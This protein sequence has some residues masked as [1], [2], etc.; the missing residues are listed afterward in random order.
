MG[1]GLELIFGDHHKY[2]RN[3]KIRPSPY[4]NQIINE[5]YHPDFEKLG[6]GLG[7]VACIP[8]TM[9]EYKREKT[10]GKKKITN[11]ASS[12]TGQ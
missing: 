2:F 5:K 3:N 8:V 7:P 11:R 10:T 1:V 12:I 6:I 9:H 4:S